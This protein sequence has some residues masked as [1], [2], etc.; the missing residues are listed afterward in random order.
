MNCHLHPLAPAV[1]SCKSCGANMCE[2]CF[3]GSEHSG[4][5]PECRREV[6]RVELA[7]TAKKRRKRRIAA[8]IWA[9]L[10]L[11]LVCAVAAIAMYS[12]TPITDYF[13]NHGKIVFF[14]IVGV[15]AIFPIA[16]ICVLVK[17]A[18]LVS[19]YCKKMEKIE[20]EIER[21]NRVMRSALRNNTPPPQ[22]KKE[23]KTLRKEIKKIK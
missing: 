21:M 6:L 15:A 18:R 2:K 3:A 20:Y 14:V 5:C 19:G 7:E 10:T 23:K 13:E 9:M 8:G 16:A 17:N 22:T 1:A 12:Y 4:L 11:L